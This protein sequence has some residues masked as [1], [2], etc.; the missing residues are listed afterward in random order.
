MPPLS[1]TPH[2][3]NKRENKHKWINN[4]YITNKDMN[5]IKNRKILHFL[6]CCILSESSN[7][8]AFGERPSAVLDEIHIQDSYYTTSK[9]L[10]CIIQFSWRNSTCSLDNPK[11][12]GIKWCWVR[13][14]VQ[15]CLPSNC[16][17][18]KKPSVMKGSIKECIS[19][20]RVENRHY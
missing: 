11:G 16:N 15:H 5:I 2:P 7:E 18:I 14:Y 1:P 13:G 12:A 19:Y 9:H 6:C 4:R 3:S 8:S 17:A 10:F 20:W